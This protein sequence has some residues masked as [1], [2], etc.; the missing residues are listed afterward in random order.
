MSAPKTLQEAAEATSKWLESNPSDRTTG[1]LARNAAGEVVATLSW[2]AC[3][4]CAL[5]YLAKEMG[6]DTGFS[7]EAGAR[8]GIPSHIA[9]TIVRANDTN[10]IPTVITALRELTFQDQ[11]A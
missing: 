2:D 9:T 7:F 10:D 11:S 3:S 5:G 6:I 4:W 1:R 8:L